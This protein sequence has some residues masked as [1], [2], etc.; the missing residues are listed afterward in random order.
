MFSFRA[1]EATGL[2][3]CQSELNG[4]SS[5]KRCVHLPRFRMKA[6]HVHVEALFDGTSWAEQAKT[7]TARKLD[8]S[9]SWDETRDLAAKS[10]CMPG[11]IS[12][13]P[14]QHG[15]QVWKLCP[16]MGNKRKRL[17]G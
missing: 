2:L 4:V 17:L 15:K 7:K 14:A 10:P 12:K 16:D 9:T 11:S 1:A 8:E 13:R 5:I 3:V 6:V